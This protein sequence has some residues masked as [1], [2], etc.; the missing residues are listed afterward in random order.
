MPR[1]TY[2]Y[3]AYGFQHVLGAADR[4]GRL[5]PVSSDRVDYQGT[6]CVG[7]SWV[8]TDRASAT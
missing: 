5:Q 4:E 6:R 8:E 3:F 7:T 1:R 2:L